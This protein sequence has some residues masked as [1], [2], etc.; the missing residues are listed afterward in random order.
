MKKTTLITTAA[1]LGMAALAVHAAP[2]GK[3]PP[4][5]QFKDL[6][7][8]ACTCDWTAGECTATWTDVNS[9]GVVGFPVSY[10]A[11]IEFEAQWIESTTL[12]DGTIAEVKREASAEVDLDGYSCNGTTCSATVPI[13]LPDYPVDATTSFMAKVKAFETGSDGLTPR[14]FVKDVADCNLPQ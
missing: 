9:L 4:V 2:P 10:G 13:V 3:S 11:D 8:P 1:T 5:N 12:A 7:A 6:L 14:N